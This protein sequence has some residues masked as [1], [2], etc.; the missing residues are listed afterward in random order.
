MNTYYINQK[1]LSLQD[2]YYIY[3]E[4]Q[5]PILQIIGNTLGGNLDKFFGSFF[6]IGYDIHINNLDGEEIFLIKKKKG[7]IWENYDIFIYGSKCASIHREKDWFKA[8][9]NI[10]SVYG[11]Y[12][13]SGNSL[14]RN[15]TILKDGKVVAKIQKKT[16]SIKDAYELCVYEE[17]KFQLFIASVIAI[18][19]ACHN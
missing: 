17:D 13:F 2:R 4:N 3:D 9:F 10:N 6:S 5:Q 14:A 11:N 15:F 16:L 8:K 1:I 7:F 12:T 19:N 18:D